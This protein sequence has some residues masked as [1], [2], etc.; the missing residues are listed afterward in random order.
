MAEQEAGAAIYV[1][2]ENATALASAIVRLYE[3]PELAAELGPR[4][5]TYV[6]AKFDYDRLTAML[7]ERIVMVLEKEAPP[8]WATRKAA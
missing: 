3:H 4:G 7:S 6:K 5:R 8:T 2:P 1:E